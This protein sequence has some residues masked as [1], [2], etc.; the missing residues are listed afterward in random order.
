MERNYE[1][2]PSHHHTDAGISHYLGTDVRGPNHYQEK[3]DSVFQSENTQ[4]RKYR[5][6]KQGIASVFHGNCPVLGMP[7][8][9]LHSMR[10]SNIIIVAITRTKAGKCS[11]LFAH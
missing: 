1:I 3:N 8:D 6:R 5:D 4:S 9:H 7:G 10:Y 11:L 2:N